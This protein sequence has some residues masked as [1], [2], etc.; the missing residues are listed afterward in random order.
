MEI[1]PIRNEADHDKFMKR[2]DLLMSAEYGTPEGDELDMLI[3]L[4]DAYETRQFPMLGKVNPIAAILFRV[5]QQGL[6]RKDLEPMIGSRARVSEV[7][8][9]KRELTLPMIRRLMAGLRLSADDLILPAP[10]SAKPRRSA[11]LKMRRSKPLPQQANPPGKRM[12]T[13]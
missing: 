9:G 7:L 13:G 3:T 6:T 2:I 5:D 4:V 10:E 8:S 1:H 12:R 11:P